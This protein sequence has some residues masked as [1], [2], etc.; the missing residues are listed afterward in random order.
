FRRFKECYL[1]THRGGA[2]EQ[3][4]LAT[5]G[6]HLNHFEKSLGE[7]FPLHTL[8]LA[9]LQA[10]VTAR[11]KKRYRGRP[12]SPVTLRKETASFRAAWNW[13]VVTGL[14]SGPFPSKGLAYPK[15]DEKPPFM[16]RQEIERRLAGA[17]IASRRAELWDCL[18][19]TNADLHDFLAL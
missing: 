15:G 2:M 10:H 18:Y 1:E 9:D 14:V 17:S 8:T 19:L 5:A 11:A 3:N 13:A 4:S 7:G 16:T 6:M 12:L